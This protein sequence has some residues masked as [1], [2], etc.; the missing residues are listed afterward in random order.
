MLIATYFKDSAWLFSSIGYEK[1]LHP[2]SP[3]SCWFTVFPQRR[4]NL[5]ESERTSRELG[6]RFS[7]PP[8]HFFKFPS[9]N[10]S[11]LFLLPGLVPNPTIFFLSLNHALLSPLL[12]FHLLIMNF[13]APRTEF[14]RFLALFL[15]LSLSLTLSIF[16]VSLSCVPSRSLSTFNPFSSIFVPCSQLLFRAGIIF[17][18][19]D[20]CSKCSAYFHPRKSSKV[21]RSARELCE[22]EE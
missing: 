13:L 16:P 12:S 2:Y 15:S 3:R 4:S 9:R 5:H 18:V 22:K 20:H 6:N 21:S 1:A 7:P 10:F 11:P 8:P 17:R 19:L 14:H